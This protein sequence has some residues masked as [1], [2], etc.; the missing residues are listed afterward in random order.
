MATRIL[1]VDDDPFFRELTQIVLEDCQ[2]AIETAEDGLAAWGILDADPVRFD[3]I[4]LDKQMPRLDGISLL[5]RIRADSRFKDLRV[6]MLTGDVGQAD[7][8][9]GLAAGAYYYLT[10]PSSDDVLKRVV[11]NALDEARQFREMLERIGQQNL[12]L[13]LL[14]RAEFTCH[15]LSEARSLALLLADASLDPGRTVNGYAELLINAIEHGNLGIT[16]EEKGRMLAQGSWSDEV[17][18]LLCDPRHAESCVSVTLERNAAGLTVTIA[19]QGN[20]FDW[21]NFM[22]FSAER[23]FDLHGRGIAMSRVLSFDSLEYLGN[24]SCVVTRVHY[25]PLS[26]RAAA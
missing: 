2:Y 13:N 17:E 11:R 12:N 25:P 23:A 19:D 14:K 18:A 3:L 16:Y 15:S 4:L 9:E 5:K 7:I 8:E 24:G 20:G 21:R 1:L 26:Q 6:I 10:K 22:E